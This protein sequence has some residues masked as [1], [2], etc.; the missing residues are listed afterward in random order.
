MKSEYVIGIQEIN[1]FWLHCS[2]STL[3]WKVINGTGATKL[4]QKPRCP[5]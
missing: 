3:M 4:S 1:I 5:W 2:L